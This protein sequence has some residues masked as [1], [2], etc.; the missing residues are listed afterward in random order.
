MSQFGATGK[1]MSKRPNNSIMKTFLK[2]S[3]GVIGLIAG[4]AL[5][6]STAQAT[7]NLLVNSSFESASLFTANPITL[8]GVN[9]GW[10]N[11]FGPNG[12]V[13]SS[14]YALDGIYSLAVTEGGASWNPAG[15][16]Q[17]VSGA[18]PGSTYQLSVSVL[19]PVALTDPNW[20]TP[21]DVQLQFFD[22]GLNN[23]S[24]TETG[25]SAVGAVGT[26]TQYTVTA[27]A[28]AG[29]VYASPYLMFMQSGGQSPT[30]TVYF[31]S[32]SL[33]VPE[34]SSLALVAMGMGLPFYFLRR[35]HS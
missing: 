24:T 8:A 2:I 30:D 3:G 15:T 16:Y 34:P 26:W 25:W 35:R 27:T 19:A 13:Q 7:P 33:T 31:D 1:L 20:S 14:A 5:S 18:T 4:L 29:A 11:Y 23:L 12:S 28:P 21:I 10:A 17:I 22:A 32:A 6:V 9:Q